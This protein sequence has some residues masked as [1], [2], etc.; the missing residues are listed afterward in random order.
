MTAR[1]LALNELSTRWDYGRSNFYL[2]NRR[3]LYRSCRFLPTSVREKSRRCSLIH[4][5]GA[6]SRSRDVTKWIYPASLTAEDEKKRRRK[7][8][9]WRA[10]RARSTREEQ[11]ERYGARLD[12]NLSR[13]WQRIEGIYERLRVI[14]SSI[15]SRE[16]ETIAMTSEPVSLD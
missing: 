13:T 1:P 5:L 9:D 11:K 6:Y 10:L 12:T 14:A 4:F 15:F 16:S 2:F 7:I 8:Q 3:R